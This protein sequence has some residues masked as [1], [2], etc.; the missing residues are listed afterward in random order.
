VWN[1]AAEILN[2][3]PAMTSPSPTWIT[4]GLVTTNSEKYWRMSRM[5]KN[6]VPA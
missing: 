6:P 3:S 5:P 4:A 2:P 1:G